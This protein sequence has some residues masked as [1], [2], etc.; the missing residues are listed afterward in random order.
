MSIIQ[1]IKRNKMKV[2][3]RLYFK[4][5]L[6]TGEYE[7]DWVRVDNG[8]FKK[9]GNIIYSVDAVKPNYFVNEGFNFELFNN[10]GLYS[11][12]GNAD[13]MFYGYMSRH[14]TLVRVDAGYELDGIEYPTTSTLY[15][16]Y[17]SDDISQKN[18]NIVSIQTKHLSSIFQEFPADKITGLGSTQTASDI[19]AKVRD[20]QD[21]NGVAI[22][23]KYIS[24]TAWIISTTTY[25]YNFATST[26][27]QNMDIWSMMQKLAEAENYLLYVSPEQKLYFVSRGAIS[28]TAD[29]HFS[30]IGDTDNTY[31][32]NVMEQI[33]VNEGINNI[34][35]RIRIKHGGDEDTITSFYIKQENWAW[36]DS[37]SSFIYGVREYYYQNDWLSSATAAS[38][39]DVIYNEFVNPKQ[40]IELSSKFVPHL[41][42]NQYVTLTYKTKKYSSGAYLWNHF[43]WGYGYWN[44]GYGYNIDIDNVGFRIIYLN[45]DINQFKSIVKL[46]AV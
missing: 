18:D 4:R 22:F 8:S 26:S 39:G 40:E 10:D 44:F 45:H 38:I 41:S 13:S 7:T 29:F 43:L 21:S 14:R 23:Q 36:G 35:N 3:R 31:G 17:I 6:T 15:I 28:T 9:W 5:R 34:Y 25:N 24:T 33:S 19:I 16:G 37:S 42:L 20:H 2:F 12:V 32:H 30:G 46:R 27:L 1:C 11:E